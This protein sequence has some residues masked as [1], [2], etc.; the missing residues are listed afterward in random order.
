MKTLVAGWFSFEQGH[1]TAGDL[2]AGE[3]ACDWLESAGYSYDIAVDPPFCGG[4]NWRFADPKNYSLVVFVCGPFQKGE[5]EAEFLAHFAGCRLIGL[6]LTMLERLDEW[7]PFD[8]LLER[9]SS[10]C[11]RPDITFL[12]PRKLVPVVGVCLVEPYGAM[13]EVA[14]AA[15]WRLVA[16][17]S[18]AVVKIDT[19]LDT[20]ITDL[21]SPSEIESL[22]ARMDLVVTTRL[23]GTVLAL[24]NGVPTISIDPE[25][26]GAKI[27]RQAQKIGWPVVFAVDNVTD[28]ALQQALDYCLSEDARIK[29]RACC[30]RAKKMVEEARDEFITALG[31]D[32]AAI[33][34]SEDSKYANINRIS[35]D[36][37]RYA[38]SD[39]LQT[40]RGMRGKM[41][42]ILKSII[43]RSR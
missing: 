21:R 26:G 27:I 37:D 38:P 20:N 25:A 8:V 22:L 11:A 23:H 24:K 7:N 33:D 17:R 29:A 32:P 19:R 35:V 42:I 30:Q 41:K 28:E 5:L 3:L 40:S 9:D 12:S 39:D 15:I 36:L 4:I 10:V 13:E 34:R 2:L 31:C 6:D 18:V 16:S 1:G 43:G 14:H